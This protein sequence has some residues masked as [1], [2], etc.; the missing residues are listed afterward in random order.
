MGTPFLRW[1]DLKDEK[2]ETV[3]GSEL[4]GRKDG[5]FGCVEL[6]LYFFSLK[7]GNSHTD[8]HAHREDN[9]KAQKEHTT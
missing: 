2:E 8:G 1:G 4:E 3:M 5:S 9:V 7:S 6:L